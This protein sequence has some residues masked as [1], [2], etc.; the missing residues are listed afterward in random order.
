MGGLLKSRRSRF[1][2]VERVRHPDGT[3]LDSGRE[4]RR[5]EEL[6]LL[7]HAGEIEEL[8]VHP[9]F[10]IAFE[11]RPVRMRSTRY[12]NGRKLTYSADFQYFDTRTEVAI[13]EDV[14]MASGHRTD[15]YKIKKALMEHMGY[16]ILE[17]V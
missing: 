13:I 14:K 7:E 11:G 3:W 5:Y 4:L 1:S 15:K 12:P 8:Q 2:N 10:V 16:K 9:K 17:S 6:K